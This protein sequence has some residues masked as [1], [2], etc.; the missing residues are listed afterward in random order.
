M[1]SA[2]QNLNPISKKQEFTLLLVDDEEGARD[3]FDFALKDCARGLV[4]KDRIKVLY[5]A[6]LRTAFKI[7]EENQVHLVLLD[8]NLGEKVP[9]EDRNG[10]EAIPEILRIQPQVQILVLSGS[11]DTLDV[12]RAMDLGATT[13]ISK[14]R[15]PELLVSQINRLLQNSLVRIQ[16]ARATRGLTEGS[17]EPGG[18]SRVFQTILKQAKVIAGSQQPAILFGETGT[19]KTEIAKWMHHV[20]SE[21]LNQKNRPFLGINVSALA[22][23]II[24]NELF[25]YEKG[26][27]T[28]ASE[29]KPGLF[30]QAE[31]GTLFLDEIG[32]LPLALQ[33][34]LLKVIDEKIYMRVGGKR[35]LNMSCRLIFATH[36]DLAKMV[37]EGTFREDLYMRITMFP[38]HVPPLS[39]RRQDIPDIIRAFLPKAC[40]SNRVHV[41]FE[42]LPEDFIEYLIRNPVRGN[43]RGLQ[44]QVDRLLVFAPRDKH[45]KPVLSRWKSISGF[46]VESTE[47]IHTPKKSNVPADNPLT[48]TELMSRP[49]SV[50][51]SDFPGF[52]EALDGIKDKIID[53]SL[54]RFKTNRDR[55]KVL[56]I[57]ESSASTLVNSKKS[58]NG[59]L[60]NSIRDQTHDQQPFV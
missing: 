57:P 2:L 32:E 60:V 7:L 17:L 5:A 33:P 54:R 16:A 1:A 26:A 24:E 41:E 55:A 6:D 18:K 19:G 50:L 20:S 34:K 13:Y 23:D 4:S 22:K 15:P 30:E 8:K 25:G 56:R 14:D 48:F 40:A 29:S 11:K 31:N 28:D 47:V 3:V 45:G 58:D 44:H 43:I 36:R 21:A 10:I 52:R 51:N 38:I 27:F 42:D 37:R 39:E 46:V 12:V 9:V 53:E 59:H 49:W 35:V